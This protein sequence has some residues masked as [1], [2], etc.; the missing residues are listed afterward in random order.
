MIKYIFHELDKAILSKSARIYFAG[1]FI[2]CILGNLAV[3]GFRTIYGTNEGTY[4]YNIMEYAA[5]SFIVPYLTCIMIVH[6]VIGRDVPREA[7][8]GEDAG[9]GP[10]A[11]LGRTQVY[12]CKLASAVLLAFIFLIICFV[13]LVSI[14]ALFQMND[15]T[16]SADTVRIFTDKMILALPLFLAGVCFGM[17]FMLGFKNRKRAYIGYYLLTLA[18]PQLILFLA[19]D[20]PGIG[21]F[22]A[23]RPYLISQCFRLI[24]YPLSPERSVP[25]IVGL[26]FFYAAVSTVTGIIAYNKKKQL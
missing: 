21:L 23:V 19:K 20:P 8:S 12:L 9:N 15:K 10:G 14:T 2:L 5:W 22:K 25:H 1:I 13:A 17:M 6:M 11:G 26:G 7:K 24:P 16:L 3:V 18:L 4:A